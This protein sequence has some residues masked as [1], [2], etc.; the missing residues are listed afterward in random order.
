MVAALNHR[1]MP[2][3]LVVTGEAE[4]WQ[5][6]LDQIVG[7][8]WLATRRVRHGEEL[9]RM[10]EAGLADAAVLDDQSD[11]GVDVLQVLRM[12]RRLDSA[13]PVVL[14]TTRS[15]RRWLEHALRLAAF[16]VVVRPL[17]LESLLRQIH[18]IMDRLD[19]MLRRGS[20]E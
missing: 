2:L 20:L 1:K 15:D 13:L 4:L 17:E 14:I 16:S 9:I 12:I 8:R 7:P 5:T 10:V 18:R 11:L 19:A 3:N 6:A